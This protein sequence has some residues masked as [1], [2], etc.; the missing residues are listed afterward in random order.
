MKDKKNHIKIHPKISKSKVSHV[1][2][3]LEV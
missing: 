1:K 2:T 3:E